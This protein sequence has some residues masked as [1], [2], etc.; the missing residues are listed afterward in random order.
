MSDGYRTPRAFAHPTR[1]NDAFDL[2]EIWIDGNAMLV[3]GDPNCPI[4]QVTIAHADGRVTSHRLPPKSATV[5]TTCARCSATIDPAAVEQHHER[6]FVAGDAVRWEFPSRSLWVE[7]SWVGSTDHGFWKEHRIGVTAAS[8]GWESSDDDDDDDD[9]DTRPP[10]VGTMRHFGVDN[11]NTS[12]RHIQRPGQACA[13]CGGSMDICGEYH[14]G[15]QRICETCYDNVGR[16]RPPA[17]LAEQPTLSA[18]LGHLKH[19]PGGSGLA[20]PCD[21]DCRKCEVERKPPTVE[22]PWMKP[23]ETPDPLEMKYDGVTLRDLIIADDWARVGERV[24]REERRLWTPT[25]R[26][27]VSAHWSA[28]LRARISAAKERERLTV[29]M[30]L[31]A[32]DLPW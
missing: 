27:A 18:R 6:C 7:G 1:V 30:P 23:G 29:C 26:A 20:G 11:D 14:H 25:Q 24:S 13:G 19:G 15:V 21:A 22:T 17:S 12:I 4:D 9:D 5:T 10:V 28:R 3:K 32:E 8:G 31:Y 16:G 2:D